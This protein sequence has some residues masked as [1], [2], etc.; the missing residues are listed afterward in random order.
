MV[1][2]H[3]VDLGGLA[4][5][6]ASTGSASWAGPVAG[7][8]RW[9]PPPSSRTASRARS[10]WP[11]CRRRRCPARRKTLSTGDRAALVLA[12]RTPRLAGR[13]LAA[14]ARRAA[15]DPAKAA[16][17]APSAERRIVMTGGPPE[18]LE[19]RFFTDARCLDGRGPVDDYRTLGRP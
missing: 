7:R 2:D 5:A 9:P 4:D 3:A 8:T 16:A 10:Q 12:R 6:L 14:V 11:A 19:M 17:Q 15:K 18:G 13:I 1:A